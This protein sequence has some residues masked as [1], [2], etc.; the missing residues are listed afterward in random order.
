MK[1][2]SRREAREAIQLEITAYSTMGNKGSGQVARREQ[3]WHPGTALLSQSVMSECFCLHPHSLSLSLP[4]AFSHTGPFHKHPCSPHTFQYDDQKQGA[5]QAPHRA[6]Q[7]PAHPDPFSPNYLLPHQPP[8]LP[9]LIL[10]T[11]P[12]FLTFSFLNHYI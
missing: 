5:H 11:L 9:P 3:R 1:L 2:A 10:S 12:S 4:L 6:L 7:A 8:H